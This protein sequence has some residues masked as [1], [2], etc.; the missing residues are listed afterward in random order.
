M[1]GSYIES[2]NTIVLFGYKF[3]IDSDSSHATY[4]KYIQSHK[5][6]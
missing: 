3:S 6:C 2:N 1:L 5:Y 4:Y